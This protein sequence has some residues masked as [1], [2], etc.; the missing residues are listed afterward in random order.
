MNIFHCTVNGLPNQ[1]NERM[2]TTIRTNM[3]H[4]LE[5]GNTEKLT[6]ILHT[7]FFY[8]IIMLSVSFFF[9]FFTFIAVV[10]YLHRNAD[11]S[12]EICE[13]A[14]KSHSQH[15]YMYIN[16]YT[17]IYIFYILILDG[18]F[19]R[20]SCVVIISSYVLSRSSFYSFWPI[21]VVYLFLCGISLF[22]IIC[23]TTT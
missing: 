12:M 14:Q 7:Q 1:E 6:L 13:C 15:I 4:I 21:L 19:C 9:F 17:N 18:T 3:V 20:Y 23:F 5:S 2:K 22:S 10:P 8:F 11:D 16:R